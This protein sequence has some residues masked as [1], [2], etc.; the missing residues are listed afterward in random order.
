MVLF[1]VINANF[2]LGKAENARAVAA[3][4]NKPE[5]PD[6]IRVDALRALQDWA[7]PKV[8]DRVIDLWR[9][10]PQSAPKRSPRKR[11]GR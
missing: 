7:R 1:H 6:M 10:L 5:V 8:R 2:R 4:V 3:L 9:P 11:C